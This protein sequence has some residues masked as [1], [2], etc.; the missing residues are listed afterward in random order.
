[1]GNEFA[2][3][4]DTTLALMDDI[5]GIPMHPSVDSLNVAVTAAIALH[6]YVTGSSGSDHG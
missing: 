1:M 2:G 3:L 6:H 5:V 4:D